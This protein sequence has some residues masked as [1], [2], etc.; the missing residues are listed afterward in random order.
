MRGISPRQSESMT[1][2]ISL[3]LGI[4]TIRRCEASLTQQTTTTTNDNKAG[5][6]S[7]GNFD[8]YLLLLFDEQEKALWPSG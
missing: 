7:D 1:A 5:T 3:V 8:I 2:S 4:S 6:T